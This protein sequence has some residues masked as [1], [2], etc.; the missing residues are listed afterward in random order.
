[1]VLSTP[2]MLERAKNGDLEAIAQLI[3]Q[4]L[5]QTLPPKEFLTK[6]TLKGSCLYLRLESAQ[7]PEPQGAIAAVQS[8]L[9]DLSLQQ[10]HQARIYGWVTGEDFPAWQEELRWSTFLVG[11][12]PEYATQAAA[13]G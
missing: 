1:M 3:N 9:A 6:A 8:I 7:S 10:V 4:R 11:C 12:G 5:V 2:E 13:F